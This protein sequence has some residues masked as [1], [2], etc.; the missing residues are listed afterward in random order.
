M[1]KRIAFGANN[2]GNLQALNGAL[3]IPDLKL[4]SYSQG[5]RIK[6]GNRST[7]F[8][9]DETLIWEA[10][11]L[12]FAQYKAAYD[13]LSGFNGQVTLQTQYIKGLGDYVYNAY[14][15]L[16]KTYDLSQTLYGYSNVE[17]RFVLTERL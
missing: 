3:S 1:V 12:T 8:E 2:S 17:I 14:M 4:R 10:T 5:E 7:H 13:F 11:A 16:P 15:Y 6:R 9:G